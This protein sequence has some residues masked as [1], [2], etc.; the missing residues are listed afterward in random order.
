MTSP[1]I[2]PPNP[3]QANLVR[4]LAALKDALSKFRVALRPINDEVLNEAFREVLD[5]AERIVGM[6]L[7]R[8]GPHLADDFAN[9]RSLFVRKQLPREDPELGKLPN[10][11]ALR[12]A[13]GSLLADLDSVLDESRSLGLVPS[14]PRLNLPASVDIERAG[15]EGQ[16]AALEQRLRNVEHQL[17]T[18]IVPEGG[19]Y[20]G[21]SPQQVGLV[22]FY[23][24]A[25][26]IKLKLA[27]LETKATALV[28][29]DSL[30]RAVEAI[31]ELTRDFVATVDGLRAKTT[32]TLKRAAQ[33]MRP[34]VRRVVVGLRTM[35]SVVKRAPERGADVRYDME[36]TLEEA[37]VGKTTQINVPIPV[38]CETCHGRGQVN[39]D[40][41]CGACDGVGRITRERVLSINIPAGIED[42]TRIRLAG[43]GEAGLHGGPP[44]DLYILLSIAPHAFFRRD[45]ADLH[46]QVPIST[47]TASLGGQVEIHA[48]NSGQI[49]LKIPKGTQV[50]QRLRLRGKGMPVLRSKKMG[51]MYVQVVVEMPTK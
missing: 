10:L 21:H 32:D 24:D 27:K 6:H 16:L 8:P 23:V 18:K 36:I 33:A 40:T 34:A 1:S 11:T 4:E 37:Y 42:G 2:A 38:T 48:I 22:N 39:G 17:E 49:H 29:F 44:G 19:F 46:C 25:M 45:G 14:D 31:A 51:D 7:L 50:G 47:S 43:E 26:R 9:L 13:R 3:R 15:R 30:S 35:V 12:S 41:K 5:D 28:D 20:E